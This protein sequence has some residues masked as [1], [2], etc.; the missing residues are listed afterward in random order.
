VDHADPD[1]EP[2]DLGG[3]PVV[4]L[5]RAGWARHLLGLARARKAAGAPPAIVMDANANVMSLAARSAELR[6]MIAES[7]GMHADGMPLV[8]ASRLLERRLPGRVAGAD[9]FH[10]VARRAVADGASFY[11]LGG[12]PAVNADADARARELYPGL[13]IV[14][15]RDGYFDRAQIGDVLAEIRAA[16][17]DVLWL[18]LGVPLEQRFAFEHRG[19]LVGVGVIK[20]CGGTF[21]YLSGHVPRAPG[22]MQR[23]G[24]EWL[25]RLGR[26]PRRLFWRYAVTNPHALVLMLTRSRSRW[27]R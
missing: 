13:A 26:E 27:R 1:L 24:T 5:D 12:T 18:G 8:L 16:R 21:D 6:R 20:T 25:F 17:P 15:R 14:G 23:T 10:D 19:A 4:P 3:L 11:L 22:W 7:D 2:V 9:F